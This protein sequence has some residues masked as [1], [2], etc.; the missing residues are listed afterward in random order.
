MSFSCTDCTFENTHAELI[1]PGSFNVVSGGISTLSMNPNG[2]TDGVVGRTV[3]NTFTGTSAKLHGNTSASF[4][5]VSGGVAVCTLFAVGVFERRFHGVCVCVC[6][7][8]C[9]LCVCAVFSAH[10]PSTTKM[11]TQRSVAVPGSGNLSYS[12][13]GSKWM[14]TDATVQDVYDAVSLA[15]GVAFVNHMAVSGT[16]GVSL[17]NSTVEQ[18]SATVQLSDRSVIV[19]GGVLVNVAD[20]AGSVFVDVTNGSSLLNNTAGGVGVREGGSLTGGL[21][22]K[23]GTRVT[24]ASVINLWDSTIA[25]C[26]SPGSGGMVRRRG[27]SFLVACSLFSHSC[28]RHCCAECRVSGTAR[29][30]EPVGA[31]LQQRYHQRQQGR[32]GNRWLDADG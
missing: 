5:V 25:G 27:A 19:A 21:L 31:A 2:S 24:G 7:C 1:A 28:A 3:R 15:G 22:V 20:S 4:A 12:D 17:Q 30:Q 8:V 23:A 11:A 16:T 10:G 14:R 32:R 6:V 26:S 13:T 29:W 18:C 9:V